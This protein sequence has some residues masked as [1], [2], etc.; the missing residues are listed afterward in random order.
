MLTLEFP[1]LPAVWRS[2]RSILYIG[3]P[4]AVTNVAVPLGIGAITRIVSG[5]GAAAVAGFGV[6][7]R[8]ETFALTFVMAL[9][10]VVAP[11]VGQNWGAR[12]FARLARGVR[13]SHWLS[14]AW[15]ALMLVVL[16]AFARP[17]AGVFN[18][19]PAVVATTALYL[20]IVPVSYGLR[21]VHFVATAAL[22]VLRR[23]I[24]AALLT[25]L[26]FF[27][28]YVPLALLGSRL[29]GLSGVFGAAGVAHIVSGALAWF[30]LRRIVA[31]RAM[32]T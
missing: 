30:W 17:L 16:A 32:A 26:Q 27:G 20:W 29:L 19:S 11:F 15:G 2:W 18:A 9:R 10:T 3:L 24:D 25:I 1:G 8:I 14:M 5:Y 7:S 23:P 13:L 31:M 6:A 4:S 12:E 22:A 28:L 21:G